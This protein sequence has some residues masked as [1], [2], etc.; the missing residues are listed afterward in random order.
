MVDIYLAYAKYHYEQWVLT[1][2]SE[3]LD[4]LKIFVDKLETLAPTNYEGNILRSIWLFLEKREIDTAIA[5]IQRSRNRKDILWRYNLAFLYAY[6]GKMKEAIREYNKASNG[7]LPNTKVLGDIIDF[8]YWV[9]EKEPNKCQLYFCLGLIHFLST[10]DYSQALREFE[11]FLELTPPDL[12]PDAT[13]TAEKY[14]NTI[15]RK[16]MPNS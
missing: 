3:P 2:D 5:E 1:R 6:E 10:E 9:V 8:I 7:Y 13:L 14:I 16:H 12:F 11:I 15:Q 4:K